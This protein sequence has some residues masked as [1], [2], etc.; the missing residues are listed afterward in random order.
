MY[1][2]RMFLTGLEPKASSAAYE[3]KLDYKWSVNN[4]KMLLDLYTKYKDHVGTLKMK[5]FKC[6]WEQIASDLRACNINVTA[7][8]CINRWRVLERNYKKFCDNQSKTGKF[9]RN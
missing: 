4:S 8:N 1:L 7:N 3:T 5:N 6:F 2:N 9:C